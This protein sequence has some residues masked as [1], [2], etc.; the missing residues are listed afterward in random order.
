MA[1]YLGREVPP[2]A[3]WVDRHDVDAEGTK[4]GDDQEADDPTAEDVHALLGPGV[5]VVDDRDGCLRC[6]QE[7]SVRHRDM[8]WEALDGG[9]LDDRDLCMRCEGKDAL[10]YEPSGH[11]TTDSADDTNE[12]VAVRHRV[13]EGGLGELTCRAGLV[14]GFEGGL[15]RRRSVG[16]RFIEVHHNMNNGSRY[17]ATAA[18]TLPD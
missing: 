11:A 17:L 8:R 2:A 9:R 6:R 3:V 5:S 14:Q 4:G 16:W 10:A 1:G 13:R 15:A 12:R 18:R 7:G